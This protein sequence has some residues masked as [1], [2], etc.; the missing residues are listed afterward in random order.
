MRVLTTAE[1]F[2]GIS[3]QLRVV[4]LY[5]SLILFCCAVSSLQLFVQVNWTGPHL[6]SQNFP[7][8][9]ALE[10]Q[11]FLQVLFFVCG[12]VMQNLN[13]CVVQASSVEN[14]CKDLLA[15]DG[16]SVYHLVHAPLYLFVAESIFHTL[17]R[18]N[19]SLQ[20]RLIL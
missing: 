7:K 13:L 20:V 10:V 2:L 3:F 5:R 19:S 8:I 18:C 11:L 9:F 15:K 1:C 4:S 14:T 17:E 16:N 6:Q 12:A